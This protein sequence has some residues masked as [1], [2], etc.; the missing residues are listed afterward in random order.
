MRTIEDYI[1]LA[2]A[3]VA[4]LTL[5]T[6]PEGLYEP[7]TYGL[8]NGGKLLRPALLLASCE[9]V[10]GD[11]EKALNQAAAIEM[12]HN[13]TLFHDDVMD[14]ADLR[15]GK[16]TVCAKWDDNTAIL[17]GDTLLTLAVAKVV[18]GVEPQKA[19]ALLDIFNRAAIEVY[20]GQQYDMMFENRDNV[21]IDDYV[22]MIRLKTSVLLGAACK[23]G[24]V[25]G[26]ADSS[27]SQALYDFAMNLGIAFQLQ[28][29][30]LDVYGDPKVF[31]KAIG[32]DI[33]NNKKTFLLINAINLAEGDTKAELNR[34]LNASHPFPGEKIAAVTSIYNQLGVDRLCREAI[35]DY[36]S[37]ARQSLS[38]SSLSDEAVAFFEAFAESLMGRKR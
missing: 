9:A 21:S 23:I 2:K 29:D 18:E 30:M 24:A 15:R 10:G 33:L 14:R 6:A 16:P 26:N 12:F 8:S 27:R 4:A 25:M 1:T 3:A 36:D 38:G 37:R 19:V 22:N 7:I 11:A 17:S 20:E 5:P 35:A 34:W 32:G 28:D 13:F 31:G